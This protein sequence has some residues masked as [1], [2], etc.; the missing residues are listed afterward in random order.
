MKLRITHRE[1][2]QFIEQGPRDVEKKQDQEYKCKKPGKNKH[3]FFRYSGER[4]EGVL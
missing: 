2:G 3:Y 1:K 4:V